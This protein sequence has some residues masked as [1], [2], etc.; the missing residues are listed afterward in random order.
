MSSYVNKKIR[1]FK[2]AGDIEVIRKRSDGRMKTYTSATDARAWCD[3]TEERR[4]HILDLVRQGDG[5]VRQKFEKNNTKTKFSSIGFIFRK[6][7]TN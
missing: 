1:V 3:S 6:I 5:K 4:Q 7:Y 2:E